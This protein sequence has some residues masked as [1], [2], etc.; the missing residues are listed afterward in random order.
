MRRKKRQ[1]SE[2]FQVDQ[3]SDGDT[4]KRLEVFHAQLF[5]LPQEEPP[6]EASETPHVRLK[7]KTRRLKKQFTRDDV[8]GDQE[9]VPMVKPV[10]SKKDKRKKKKREEVEQVETVEKEQTKQK[11]KKKK[12]IVAVDSAVAK[13]LKSSNKEQSIVLQRVK[14]QEAAVKKVQAPQWHTMQTDCARNGD[15]DG[16][17]VLEQ[18]LGGVK[19]AAMKKLD[20]LSRRKHKAVAA[21]ET[22]AALKVENMKA[23][24]IAAVMMNAAVEKDATCNKPSKRLTKKQKKKQKKR[25]MLSSSEQTTE[26]DVDMPV[27]SENEEVAGS[28]NSGKATKFAV[29][30]AC[31][32][33][34]ETK[35]AL[36]KH[37]DKSSSKAPRMS[38]QPKQGKYVGSSGTAEGVDKAVPKKWQTVP[39][40]KVKTSGKCAVADMLLENAD[41]E[42]DE[43]PSIQEETRRGFPASYKFIDKVTISQ[44][45]DESSPESLGDSDDDCDRSNTDNTS[46]YSR[47]I[48]SA[49]RERW[50]LVEVGRLVRL[51]ATGWEYEENTTARFLCET[52]PELVS[53]DFL[54]GLGVNLSAKQLIEIFE[55]GSGNAGVFM[56]KMA[57]AVENGDLSMRDPHFIATLECRVALMELNAEVLELL[58]PLLESLSTVRDVGYLLQQLCEHWQ[59]ERKLALVQQV[60]L[61]K[62]FDD[63]DGN[64]NEI[65]LDLPDLAGR[66][67]FPSRLDQEDVDENGNL[68]G[69]LVNDD[70]DLSGEEVS[71]EEDDEIDSD[72]DGNP[73]AGESES[74]EEVTGR[75]PGSNRFIEEEADVGEDDDDDDDVEGEEDE[76]ER[77]S[78]N[79]SSSSDSD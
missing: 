31:R 5:N 37:T 71:G 14:C 55:I 76:I 47:L 46:L 72:D 15:D 26:E 16:V 20:G 25:P 61:S 45:S 70:S 34:K 67:D 30:R 7:S 10:T 42:A 57:S 36:A 48:D 74:D 56:N 24:G 35:R 51:F 75:T 73:Y 13:P 58:Y 49:A 79:A 78:Q 69:F 18:A 29:L 66:L 40:K 77:R 9:V 62:V 3:G 1:R 22:S 41:T 65:L 8:V 54:E 68:K 52:C 64:Q 2:S 53:V 63:L 43:F 21:D 59:L 28:G 32:K 27:I 6:V 50:E 12:V 23:A 33:Q 11:K 17:D 4:H 38:R 60:L 39:G 19:E 44:V